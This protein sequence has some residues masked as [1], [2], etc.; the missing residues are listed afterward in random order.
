MFF[1]ITVY[2]LLYLC[3]HWLMQRT[4]VG[5]TFCMWFLWLFRNKH[6]SRELSHVHVVTHVNRGHINL[7]CVSPPCVDVRILF[8]WAAEE[9]TVNER[10]SPCPQG[11]MG[12]RRSGRGRATRRSWWTS[13]CPLGSS[14]NSLCVAA[15]PSKASKKYVRSHFMMSQSLIDY[16]P[17][18][19]HDV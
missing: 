2:F 17:P 13:C 16:F 7:A 11:S 10:P 1:F 5:V 12:C 18:L 9:L 3:I 8:R 4:A 6:W 19:T 14:S 15:T